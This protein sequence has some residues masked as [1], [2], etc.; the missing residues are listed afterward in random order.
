MNKILAWG[1]GLGCSL[2]TDQGVLC[3]GLKVTTRASQQA[4]WTVMVRLRAKVSIPLTEN[5]L[6]G[7]RSGALSVASS[8]LLTHPL[9]VTQS[10]QPE[11]VPSVL[12]ETE[13]WLMRVKARTPFFS[14]PTMG[15]G[16]KV[17]VPWRKWSPALRTGWWWCGFSSA[18]S[19]LCLLHRI[20]SLRL[21]HPSELR[22]HLSG[23]SP[24]PPFSKA[25]AP[26]QV[27]KGYSQSRKCTGEKQP[28][29]WLSTQHLH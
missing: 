1:W 16:E 3:K 2:E 5:Q 17:L 8:P 19:G 24:L 13:V 21:P 25:A 23:A 14:L 15:S 6:P 28:Q 22:K 12:R 20:W 29:I 11:N 26:G 4:L 9:S 7:V 10:V 18:E 27:T